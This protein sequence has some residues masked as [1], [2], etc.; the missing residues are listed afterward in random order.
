M[1]AV[2]AWAT[3]IRLEFNPA[4]RYEL[5][6][7]MYAL[8]DL[9]VRPQMIDGIATYECTTWKGKRVSSTRPLRGCASAVRQLDAAGSLLRMVP[10]NG[11][12]PCSHDYQLPGE[13]MCVAP[14]PGGWLLDRRQSLMCRF[15]DEAA[16]DR[17]KAKNIEKQTQQLRSIE[18]EHFRR[19]TEDQRWDA[20]PQATKLIVIATGKM[21]GPATELDQ[22][23]INY[24]NKQF[25]AQPDIVA[26][27][28]LWRQE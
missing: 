27:R 4:D 7:A 24:M 21:P 17:A 20:L 23:S 9:L 6:R 14:L 16:I 25:D 5:D 28:K 12:V 26:V 1:V 22:G 2:A 13:Q 3:V 8:V 15:P 18:E 11:C 10:A 19:T